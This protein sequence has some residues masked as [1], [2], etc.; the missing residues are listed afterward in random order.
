[1]SE[2]STDG[3]EPGQF[4]LHGAWNFRDTGGLRTSDGGRT[5][6]GLLF[7]AS[8]LTHLSDEGRA[9]LAGLGVSD[10]FDLRG[11]AEVTRWGSDRAPDTVTVH[12]VPYIAAERDAPHER[13][14]PATTARGY[15]DGAY[16]AFPTLPGARVAI[17]SV[18]EALSSGTSSLVHCAAGKDRAGW[19]VATVLRAA[20]VVEEDIVADY[21]RSNAAVAPLR[22]HILD[23]DEVAPADLDDDLLGVR[24][25]YYRAGLEAMTTAHGSFDNYLDW[26]GLDHD[27]VTRLR[28]ALV[29]TQR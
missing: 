20:G 23:H 14:V 21:L 12:R 29:D 7:R 2:L 1:V 9:T 3:S 13:G 15:L 8:A 19:T 28:N 4:H 16:R 10:V 22:R 24:E 18:V 5:R 25:E 17:R 11:D 27:A 26:L 6:S